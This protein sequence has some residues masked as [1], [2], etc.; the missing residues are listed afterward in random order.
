MVFRVLERRGGLESIRKSEGRLESRLE[1]LTH[2]AAT[3][4]RRVRD[5]EFMT[6]LKNR[7]LLGLSNTRVSE[8]FGHNSSTKI[9]SRNKSNRF[10]AFYIKARNLSYKRSL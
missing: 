8:R 7:E 1:G 3:T 6:T 5:R 4:K 9:Y 10:R 2:A